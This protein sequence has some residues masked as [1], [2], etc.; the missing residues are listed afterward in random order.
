MGRSSPPLFVNHKSEEGFYF[1]LTVL[2]WGHVFDSL[3]RGVVFFQAPKVPGR[4][5]CTFSSVFCFILLCPWS[6]D[7]IE[8]PVPPALPL[9]E[10]ETALQHILQAW[11]EAVYEGVDPDIIALAAIFAALSDMVCA[12]GEE[13]VA[14]MAETLPKRIRLGEFT[15]AKTLQ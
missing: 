7:M 12:H 14:I 1:L 2:E 5:P 4:L 9:Q 10:K 11:E 8:C 6:F 13:K 15:L 3:Y